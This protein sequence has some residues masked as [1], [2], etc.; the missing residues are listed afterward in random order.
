M[1]KH[2]YHIGF[3]S[4]KQYISQN[5]SILNS[6]I[7]DNDKI[8][9]SK[10]FGKAYYEVAMYEFM[11]AYKIINDTKYSLQVLNVF[12]SNLF[13]DTLFS[14]L[15]LDM[16][17]NIANKNKNMNRDKKAIFYTFVYFLFENGNDEKESIKD[18][19][20]RHYFLHYL[21]TMN[22]ETSTNINFQD[23]TKSY[24]KSMKNKNITLKESYKILE[25]KEDMEDKKVI[26]YILI[27][28]KV[29]ITLEGKSIKTLRKKAYKKIFFWLI[30][31][32]S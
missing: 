5:K 20:F 27:D 1:A 15:G 14:H 23:M 26:F 28:K 18:K 25:N 7:S 22:K 6:Y 29:I 17:E 8:Q 21:S 13:V 32:Y 24:I 10:L 30:D 2:L 11:K 31:S 3:N 16:F 9:V 12:K 4:I 19:L